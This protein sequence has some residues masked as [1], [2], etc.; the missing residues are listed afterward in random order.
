MAI[1]LNGKNLT[2]EKLV[3]IARNNE[4]VELHPDAIKRIENCREMLEE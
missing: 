2:I 1:V 3:K 4:Q